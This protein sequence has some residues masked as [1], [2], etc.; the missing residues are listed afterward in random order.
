M[1]QFEMLKALAETNVESLMFYVLA[2]VSILLAYGVILDRT[3]IRS[4]FILIGVFGSIC[5]LFLLLQ[6]Q[7]LAL[8][9]LMIYAV[10]ITLVI[11][12]AL[13]LTN[14]RMEKSQLSAAA[15][16]NQLGAFMVAVG[17]FMT[18]YLSVR[19]ENWTLSSEPLDTANVEVLGRALTTDYSL[20]FEFASVLLLAALIG[21][22]MLA[23][24]EKP[25]KP[26]EEDFEYSVVDESAAEPAASKR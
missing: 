26:G 11:V 9:Q 12:I 8:A 13:M 24:A 19:P 23:K 15:P 1:E 21:A 2:T 4:G 22:I 6:A 7:F 14:P 20:P 10:G 5:G 17:L 18:I 3:I 16:A 25:P